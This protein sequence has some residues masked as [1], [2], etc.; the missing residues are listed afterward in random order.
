[1]IPTLFVNETTSLIIP[2]RIVRRSYFPKRL[3]PE[4]VSFELFDAYK[5]VTEVLSVYYGKK[6]D[7]G[8]GLPSQAMGFLNDHHLYL[9]GNSLGF[10]WLI[11]FVAHLENICLPP[12]WLAWGSILPTRN[13]SFVLNATSHTAEKLKFVCEHDVSCIFTHRDEKIEASGKIY[14]Y[15]GDMLEIINLLKGDLL[16]E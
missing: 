7:L 14:Q 2:W 6:I 9:S 16:N 4:Q 15:A 5:N 12:T 1:M 8:I 11:G 3:I 13:R 10:A